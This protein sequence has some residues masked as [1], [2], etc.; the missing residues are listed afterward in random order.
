M[1]LCSPVAHALPLHLAHAR[2]PASLDGLRIGFL[3]NTKAPVDDMLQYLAARIV[4]AVPGA[5]V[6]HVAKQHP[7]LPAEP[8]VYQALADNA[9][10]VIN[11]LGD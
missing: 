10:V 9:D 6:F 7:S 3:D 5:T 11:A 8:E 2:R 1:L 4:E